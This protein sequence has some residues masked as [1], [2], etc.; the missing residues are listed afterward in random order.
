MLASKSCGWGNVNFIL[1]NLSISVSLNV[2]LTLM[3]VTRLVLHS[4]NI[5]TITGSRAVISRLY[6]TVATMLIESSA[7]Y[8]V[9]SLVLIGLWAARSGAA[10]IFLP[11]F[12]QTQVRSF[13]NCD[14]RT[15]YLT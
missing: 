10:G 9:N 5:R 7:L 8:S 1:L 14:S 15:D 13:R 11:V 2:I 12:S 3:I 4:R 6:K